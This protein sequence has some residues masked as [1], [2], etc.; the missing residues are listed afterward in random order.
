[1]NDGRSAEEILSLCR[2]Q[3]NSRAEV[4]YLDGKLWDLGRKLM[5]F[6][7]F[8]SCRDQKRKVIL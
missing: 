4:H 7:I 3:K 2:C 6:Y 8:L 1:M 5:T